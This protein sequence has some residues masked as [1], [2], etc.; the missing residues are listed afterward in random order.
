MF[1]F[2]QGKEYLLTQELTLN[3]I[4]KENGVINILVDGKVVYTKNNVTI[5][6]SPDVQINSFL[7]ST[8][9]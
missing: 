8:F 7:F 4:G 3:D 9:F 2:I 6:V 5:R 1:K